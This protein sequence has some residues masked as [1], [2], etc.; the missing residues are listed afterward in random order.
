MSNQKAFTAVKVVAAA[1]EAT[2]TNGAAVDL[3][4]Y[5]NLGGRNMKGIL[6]M[7]SMAGS[8]SVTIKLQDNTTSD[9]TGFTD[10]SNAAF[11]ACTTS[12]DHEEVHFI[13]KKRYI[14]AVS[15]FAAANTAYYSVDVLGEKRYA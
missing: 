6:S 7:V 12:G 3:K 4:G 14:R 5:L 9:T 1:A 15:T 10:I 2:S 8:T 13:T 11:T